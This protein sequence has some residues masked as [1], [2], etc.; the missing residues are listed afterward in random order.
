MGALVGEPGGV[1]D[2][3]GDGHLF[4]WGLA[5]KPGRGLICWELMCG[6]R[7]ETG[8]FP[9]RGPIGGP[10]EGGPSTGNFERWMK[11]A[12][13]MGHLTQKRLTAEGLEGRL[14]YCVPWVMKGR[15]WGQTSL[16]MGAQLGNLEWNRLPE[17][18]TNG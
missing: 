2:C 3:S 8:V 10:W 13:W 17:T 12:L 5:G 16:F 9:Y 18:L 6:R 11:G 4:P 15:L 14:L 7:S 1:K